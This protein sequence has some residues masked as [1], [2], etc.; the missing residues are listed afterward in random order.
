MVRIARLPQAKSVMMLDC[1]DS[2]GHSCGLHHTAPLVGVQLLGTEDIGIF[3]A[4]AP[5]AACEGVDAEVYEADELT[6]LPFVLLLR[7]DHV[8]GFRDD[9]FELIV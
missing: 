9:V 7:W 2:L 5:F 4:G 1:Q 3:P 8:R 6:F